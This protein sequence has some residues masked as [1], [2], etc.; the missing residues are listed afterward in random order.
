MEKLE[1]CILYTWICL[2]SQSFWAYFPIEM[3]HYDLG[4]LFGEPVPFLDGSLSISK[5]ILCS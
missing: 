1:E 2:L 3:S 5:V 4:I